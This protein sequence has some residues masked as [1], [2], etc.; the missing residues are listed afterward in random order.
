MQAASALLLP[1]R[2]EATPLV[3]LE[4]MSHRLPWI[5]TPGCGAV[6]EHAGGIVVPLDA[7][8]PTAREL[9]ADEPR[10]RA[11]GEAGH[12]HWAACYSWEHIAPRY[13]ALLRGA[14]ELPPLVAPSGQ[15][16]AAA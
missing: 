9:L 4:A 8:L 5:A 1:S 13:D 2:V 15:A 12:D 14:R 7:F 16:L 6:H 11:L 3:V 10:R